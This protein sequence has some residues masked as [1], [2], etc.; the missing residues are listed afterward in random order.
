MQTDASIFHPF[1]E[2]VFVLTRLKLK[3]SVYSNAGAGVVKPK[4]FHAPSTF[5]IYEDQYTHINVAFFFDWHYSQFQKGDRER[6]RRRESHLVSAHLTH[7]ASCHGFNVVVAFAVPMGGRQLVTEQ[8]QMEQ[9][10]FP[11]THC[12]AG[13]VPRLHV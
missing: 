3:N 9:R 2:M 12:L 8:Q 1:I 13:A 10:R 11:R 4:C 7:G 5:S 6:Q